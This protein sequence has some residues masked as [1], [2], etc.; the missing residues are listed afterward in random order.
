VDRL[1]LD[2]KASGAMLGFYLN[3]HKLA[4]TEIVVTLER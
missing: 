1:P 2:E 3:Q 4:T